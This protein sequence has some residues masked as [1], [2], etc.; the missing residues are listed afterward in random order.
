MQRELLLTSDGSATIS[1]QNGSFTYHS[2]HGAVQESL[3]VFIQ[4]GLDYLFKRDGP[5]E[6]HVFEVGFGTGLNALLSLSY[7][8]AYGLSL[9]YTAI[10]AFPLEEQL[11][12]RL[13]YAEIAD[14][15][16]VARQHFSTMHQ[17]RWNKPSRLTEHFTLHKV[18]ASLQEY[19]HTEQYHLIFFDAF[20]P[21]DQPELWTLPIFQ[22][23]F[24]ALLPGGVLV[25]Y[26]A[27]GNVR[28]MLQQVGFKVE[29][30]VGPPKKREMIRAHK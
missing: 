4:A 20:A 9:S 16:P 14:I 13:N 28:R 11:Y 22:K 1:C 17:L 24:D 2:I 25:T 5:K 18:L 21:D 19:R 15:L 3:H 7:A 27:K 29:R 12:Q 6:I 23:L 10:E 30:L 8:H 26:C